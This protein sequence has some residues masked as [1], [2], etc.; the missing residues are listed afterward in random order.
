MNTKQYLS[1]IEAS[2]YLCG[3]GIPVARQTLAKFATTGGGP[4]F[5]R[6][7]RK[8]LDTYQ[9]LEEWLATRLSGEMRTTSEMEAA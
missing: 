4:R 6:F 2:N 3:R 9:S 8:P 7:G 5:V 1:R